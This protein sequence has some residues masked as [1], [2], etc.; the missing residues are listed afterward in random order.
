[1]ERIPR[2]NSRIEPL[3]PKAPET[4]FAN[5]QQRNETPAIAVPSPRGK[6]GFK[7]CRKR[8]KEFLIFP[9]ECSARQVKRPIV[10][11]LAFG[12][13]IKTS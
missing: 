11:Q 1:M 5:T 12:V 2:K 9:G 8:R 13:M 10:P 4:V 3:N 7:K 6:R